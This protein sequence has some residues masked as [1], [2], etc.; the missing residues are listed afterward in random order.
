MRTDKEYELSEYCLVIERDP[1]DK[2]DL[3]PFVAT[4]KE[5]PAVVAGGDSPDEAFESLK[6]E[7]EFYCKEMKKR[8][9]PIPLP[10]PR[11]KYR[12]MITLRVN[13]EEHRTLIDRARSEGISVN[14]FIKRRVLS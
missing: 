12:G 11:R 7:F 4:I 8:K 14:K 13:S 2:S 9:R 3:P 10:F 1:S 6:N 5:V